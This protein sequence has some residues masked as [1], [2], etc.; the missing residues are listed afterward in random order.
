MSNTSIE[1]ARYNCRGAHNVKPMCRVWGELAGP[2]TRGGRVTMRAALGGRLRAGSE[3]GSEGRSDEE[4]QLVADV[5]FVAVGQ[6][7]GG[8]DWM[9]VARAVPAGGRHVAGMSGR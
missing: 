7:G 8:G 4:E 5:E 2:A 1:G 6:G 9:P 3:S